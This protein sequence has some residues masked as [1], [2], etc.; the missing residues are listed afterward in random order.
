MPESVHMSLLSARFAVFR[1][2]FA[3]LYALGKES[4]TFLTCPK[5]CDA[6]ME[7]F[8]AKPFR[9]AG[10]TKSAGDGTGPGAGRETGAVGWYFGLGRVLLAM[11][12]AVLASLV[13]APQSA[14]ADTGPVSARIEFPAPWGPLP[15][16]QESPPVERR[17]RASVRDIIRNVRRFVKR[18]TYLVTNSPT[19]WW[20]RAKRLVWPVLFAFGA[21]L[22]DPG[23]L[24]AWKN[25]GVRVLATYVPM[26]IYVYS[27]LFVS[28]G[29]SVITRLGVVVALVYGVWRHDV[30][31]DGRWNS[32]GLGRFD[33]L[34]VIALAVRAFV[35]SCP[36]ELVQRYAE[37]AIAIRNRIYRTVSSPG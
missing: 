33:D 17:L 27:R 4:L 25:D 5:H 18:A 22:F 15:L 13:T 16:L 11:A 2:L 7:E 9:P 20:R 30:F 35:A 12:L 31:S 26:M 3:K 24:S 10:L 37:R 6:T 19:W 8:G 1:Q 36:E 23:L 32:V 28:N 34:V 14:V 21:L 29:V